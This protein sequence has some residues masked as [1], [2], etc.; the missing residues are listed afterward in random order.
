ME[1]KSNQMM[2]KKTVLML[3]YGASCLVNRNWKINQHDM[4]SLVY[5]LHI[6]LRPRMHRLFSGYF[7]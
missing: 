1:Q 2:E 6:L 7:Y 5:R 4:P 3:S